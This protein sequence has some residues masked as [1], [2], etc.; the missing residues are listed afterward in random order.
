MKRITP[1]KAIRAKCLEC[2]NDSWLEVKEC[3][4]TECPLWEFRFGK[5]PKRKKIS[6]SKQT[7]SEENTIENEEGQLVQNQFFDA[8]PYV[9]RGGYRLSQSGW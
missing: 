2:S 3:P 1:M 4:V 6:N 8:K 9:E 7:R 5:N